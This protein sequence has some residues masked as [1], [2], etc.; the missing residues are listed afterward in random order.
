[1]FTA[2]LTSKGQ[3]TI[4]QAVRAALGLHAGTKVDFVAVTDG[5][6]PVPHRNEAGR[7]VR[8]RMCKSL[9]FT[10]TVSAKNR[11]ALSL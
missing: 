8:N 3:V 2:K 6:K 10:S 4:P 7:R 11:S 9:I 1:M 5:F